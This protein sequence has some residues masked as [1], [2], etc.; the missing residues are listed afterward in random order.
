MSG[1]EDDASNMQQTQK[2]ALHI[3]DADDDVKIFRD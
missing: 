1:F 2:C 3:E